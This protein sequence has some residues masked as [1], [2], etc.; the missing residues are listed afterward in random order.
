MGSLTECSLNHVTYDAPMELFAYSSE[1]ATLSE[2]ENALGGRLALLY[3][4][5]L[6]GAQK[7]LY[8]SIDRKAI[9]WAAASGFKAKLP[10]GRLIGPY[11]PIL[12]SPAIAVSFLELLAAEQEHST[13]SNRIRQV[14]ILTVGSVWHSD[15]ER[16]AHVAVA[17]KAGLP[18]PA[19]QALC[20]GESAPELEPHEQLA[21]EVTRQLT[22]KHEIDDRL[23]QE[24]LVSFGER[25]LLD[26]V[27]L[28]GCYHITSS[29]LNAFEVPAPE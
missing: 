5:Q 29:L 21:Q 7:N 25:G 1:E 28:A 27:F 9:P 11:N 3:P 8:T 23:Y 13:L 20:L 12:L 24:A 26:L 6:D 15:Y 4:Q 14:I 10:D 16:Y 19:I 17:R 18:E 2:K 22:A